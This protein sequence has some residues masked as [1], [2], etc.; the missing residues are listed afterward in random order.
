MGFTIEDRYLRK[1]LRVSKDYA[2]A[3]KM[4]PDNGQTTEY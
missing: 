4:F 2:A 1:C 3:N